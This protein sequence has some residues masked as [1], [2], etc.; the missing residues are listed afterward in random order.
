VIGSQVAFR[1]DT[2]PEDGLR[3][4]KKLRTRFAIEDAALALFGEQGYD[5]TTVEQIA[6]RAEVSTTTFFRY[7]P[8]KAEVVLSDQGQQLPALHQAIVDRPH[9]ESDLV[10]CRHAVV[11]AW[12]TAIDP[13]RTARK[14]AAVAVTPVLQGLSYQN[15]LRWMETI[16][17]ALAK[18]RG[19][20]KPDERCLLAAR[21]V[22]G[23]LASAMEGWMARECVGDLAAAVE[24]RFDLMT[25]HC[26]EWVAR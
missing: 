25:E 22:L 6:E 3:S 20:T 23:V 13:A 2:R 16:P 4:R 8:T 5:A 11:E 15:G 9:D 24:D 12:V 1:E 10:A 19:L 21:V 26:G 17:D 7:F 14:A 18:R